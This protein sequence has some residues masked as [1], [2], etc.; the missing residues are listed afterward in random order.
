MEAYIARLREID[1][2]LNEVLLKAQQNAND[3]KRPPGF[4]Y[5]FAIAEIDR[6]IEGAPFNATDTSTNSPLWID[7]REKIDSLEANGLIDPEAAERLP[8]DASEVLTEEV[9]QAYQAV[10]AW[11]MTDKN[12]ADSDPRGVWA[13]PDGDA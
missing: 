13:L 3:G 5:D 7:T 8:S 11:L 1:R 10:K 12:N 9:L 2:V 6:I 4:A